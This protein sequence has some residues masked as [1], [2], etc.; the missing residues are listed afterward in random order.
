MGNPEIEIQKINA[1]LN[2]LYQDSDEEVMSVE[3]I[4]K[5]KKIK[6]L[7][8]LIAEGKYTVNEEKLAKILLKEAL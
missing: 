5:L 4:K 1:V 8:K 6:R 2:N 7:K 3:E